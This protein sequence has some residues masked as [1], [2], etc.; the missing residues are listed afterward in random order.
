M[1]ADLVAG[2]ASSVLRVT[3][4]DSETNEPMDLSGRSVM[5]RYKLSGGTVVEKTMTVLDQINQRGKAEYEFQPADL[6]AAGLLEYEVRLDD[7]TANQLTSIDTG[8]L[9]VRSE[10]V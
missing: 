7:G 4:L 1:A 2:D 5:L 9:A 6:T 8:Q 3:V 10:L